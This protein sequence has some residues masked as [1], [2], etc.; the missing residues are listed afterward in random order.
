MSFAVCHDLLLA[1][2][3][4]GEGLSRSWG[5]VSTGQVFWQVLVIFFFILLNGFFVAA[6][7]AL[8]KVRPS[9]LDTLIESG[10]RGARTA[11]HLRDNLEA[12]LSANQLGITFASIALGFL[13]Q[14]YVMRLVQPIFYLIDD[15][16]SDGLVRGTSF[17]ISYGLV[18]FL[19]VV[20]GE[21]APKMLGLY[22]PARTTLVVA[23]PLHLFYLLF[24]PV[25]WLVNMSSNLLLGVVLRTDLAEG[26]ELHHSAEELAILVAESQRSSE[27]TETERDILINAL[28]LND[29]VVRN[30]MTPRNEVVSLD[31]TEPFEKNFEI[32]IESKHTRFPLVT[33]HLDEALGL[34]HIKDMMPLIGTENPD[35]GE[36]KRELLPVPDTMPLD[37]LLKFFLNRHAHIALVM[38]EFGGALGIVTLDNVLEELVGEIQDEFDDE[39]PEFERI[40]EDE[41]LVEGALGLY[42]L[43]DYSDLD[44]ESQDVSTVG[45]Y[46]TH[47]LEHLP[48]VGESVAIDGYTV[49]ITKANDRRVE[50]LRFM[51]KEPEAEEAE[52]RNGEDSRNS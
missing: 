30:I 41:F 19:H 20:V 36:I 39:K 23:R 6:E 11:K 34:I 33:G 40:N 43:S 27:V 4:I 51:R 44:L 32:A 48:V 18:T 13:G 7:F 38:D 28:E 12:Y 24:K 8:V 49:T 16:V 9:Q 46:V 31:F 25:I 45:G 22:H 42:E 17:A 35:L 26:G 21:Q 2:T 5:G 1:A 47:I 50:Q 29:L 52:A 10:R 37:R 3:P 15:N 14:T